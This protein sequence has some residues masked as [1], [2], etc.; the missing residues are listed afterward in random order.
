MPFFFDLGA[1][2]GLFLSD[3]L[4]IHVPVHV[5][6]MSDDGQCVWGNNVEEYV[7][8]LNNITKTLGVSYLSGAPNI[9]QYYSPPFTG[10]FTSPI[11]VSHSSL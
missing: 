11:C 9:L 7:P 8:Y 10:P 5:Q 3:E 2:A 4:Q 1:L 6:K